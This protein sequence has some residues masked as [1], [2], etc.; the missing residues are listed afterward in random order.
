[1]NFLEVAEIVWL[2]C[3]GTDSESVVVLWM[4]PKEE[5][6]AK[7]VEKTCKKV[8]TSGIWCDIIT[9]LSERDTGEPEGKRMT[10]RA[11]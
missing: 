7:N 4:F 3:A 5:K 11:V 9:G 6:T 1:M 2:F 8:L 10:Q